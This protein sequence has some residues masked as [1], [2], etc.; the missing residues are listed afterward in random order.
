MG[1]T[2]YYLIVWDF[3]NFAK[4]NGIMVGPGRGSGAGSL[5]AY[6][7]GITDVDPI[8]YTLVFERFL[9]SERVSMPDFDVDFCYE[10][11]QEVIDYVTRKYGQDRVAQV[12]TFGTLAARSCIR[13]V[14]RVLDLPYSRTD[15][16]AKMIPESMGMTIKAAMELRKDMREEYEADPDVKKV[17]DIAMKLEGMP[18]HASTHAAGVIISG[19]PI[20]D[21][22]PLS[23]N[24]GN[25]VVQFAKADI[26]SVGLLKFDFL[27]LRTLTVLRDAADSI[28]IRSRLMI[29]MFMT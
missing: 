26:E 11:R 21:I 18:R 27:G 22:A 10:R 9:N 1:Y 24:D 3:I 25:V 20:T 19:V 13:D 12:I 8:K 15:K 17:L 2:D 7:I 23:V 28:S 16:I 29:R 4:T 5:A 6:A 14:S